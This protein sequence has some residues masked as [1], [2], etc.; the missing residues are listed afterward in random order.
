MQE[1]ESRLEQFVA[2]VA[3]DE[4]IPVE[5]LR[6]RIASGVVSILGAPGHA[7]V[8]P[9]GVGHG[10]RAKVN[11]NIGISGPPFDMETALTQLRAALDAGADAVMDLSCAGDLDAIRHALL[12]ECPAPFGTVPMYQAAADAIA[13]HGSLAKATA[14][15]I[16]A[17]FE[18]HVTDGVDFFVAHAGLTREVVDVLKASSRALPVVSRGGS[19]MLSWMAATGAENPLYAQ[20]DWLLDLAAKHGATISLGDALRSGCIHDA[21]DEPKIREVIVLGDLVKRARQRGVHVL[22][23]GPG[24]V[25]LHLV[26]ELVDLIKR[27]CHGAP[28]YLLGPLVTDVAPGYD[29]IVAAIGA[30]VAAARGADF[31][32]YV[33]PSEHAG[34]PM[35]DAVRQGVIA[36]RI[37]AHAGDIARGLPGA[38]DMDREMTAA[39]A[40]LDWERQ[41]QCAIDPERLRTLHGDALPARGEPCT[42]CGDMCA[43]RITGEALDLWPRSPAA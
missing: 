20:F 16:L 42:M 14:E 1:T 23:E 32:C 38:A 24:H 37:A 26:N 5:T 2:Q 29:H 43:I 10:L 22:V 40:R 9:I 12:R 33:T 19:L 36:S 25:P 18:R 41:A 3:R 30:A 35:A 31:I 4:N 34:L 8:H 7:G 15:D 39:R 6:Q 28:L 27:L 11:A 21:L 17:A 13:Q